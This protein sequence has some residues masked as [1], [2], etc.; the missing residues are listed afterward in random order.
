[1]PSIV[2]RPEGDKTGLLCKSRKAGI[3]KIPL[4]WF[5]AENEIGSF[6]LSVV[7]GAGAIE[8]LN[9]IFYRAWNGPYVKAV[10]PL[11]TYP[12]IKRQ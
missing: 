12:Q 2:L 9:D 11:F 8:A 3:N 5:H 7:E 1:M 6:E 4:G 10:D